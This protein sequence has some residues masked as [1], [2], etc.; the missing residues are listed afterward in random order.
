MQ[1]YRKISFISTSINLSFYDELKQETR[2]V[3]SKT[4][5]CE[6]KVNVSLFCR[7]DYLEDLKALHRDIYGYYKLILSHILQYCFLPH[8]WFELQ[9]C[10]DIYQ[11]VRGY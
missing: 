7:S 10:L 2:W 6:V 11:P 1:F 3:K 5:L 8:K 4:V 9:I